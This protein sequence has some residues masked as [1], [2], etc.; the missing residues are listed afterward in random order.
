MN[1]IATINRDHTAAQVALIKRT[2]A[3]DCDADE[4]NLFMAA[5]QRT[6]L[7]PLRK[8]ISA[9]VFNKKRADKRQ[10]AIIT[11]IDGLRVIASRCGD[12]RPME[13]APR[14]EYDET[15]KDPATNPLGIVRA[16]VI[17]FKRHGE[18]WHPVAGEAYWDEFAPIED[19]WAEGPDGRRAKTGK[20]KL[21]DTW[22][23]MGRL[24]IAKCAEGQA[25]RRGW[26]DDLAGL[27]GE[28]EMQKAIVIDV[29]SEIIEDYEEQQRTQ[30]IGHGQGLMFQTEAGAPLVHVERGKIADF[31]YSFYRNADTA[32]QIGKFREI[33]AESLKAFWAWEPGD[34]HEIKQF[35]EQRLEA[36]KQGDAQ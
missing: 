3:K 21:S 13:T 15:A 36:F 6:R 14:I 27:Y 25:L 10:L 31:L 29:A 9:I 26:P 12:Y 35:A 28:D 19:E 32:E 34:A 24:M 23:R 4:F 20:R 11:T 2:V 1:A 22:K 5:A 18:E 17:C 33:N 7:D 8:Q 30:R 16:E